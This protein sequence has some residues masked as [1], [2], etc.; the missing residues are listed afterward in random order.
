MIHLTSRHTRLRSRIAKPDRVRRN[1]SRHATLL[2]LVTAFAAVASF[3]AIA[4][5]PASA[6]AK[7][8]VVPTAYPT[9][10][11]AVDAAQS[12]DTI[13]VRPGTYR[14]QV[15]IGKNLT[16]IGSGP[17]L[18]TIRAPQTLAGGEDG[19]TS[20]VEIH[21]GASV[22]LSR[23]AVSGPGSGTCASGALGSGIRVLGGG[24]LDLSFARV[25]HLTDTPAAP[26]GIGGIPIRIGN[27][28]VGAGSATI[29]YTQISDYQHAGVVVASAEANATLSHDVITGPEGLSANG[30]EF[31][32]G[33]TGTVSDSIISGNTCRE[34]DPSCGPDIFNDAQQIGIEALGA[35]VAITRD[36]LYGNQI[37][38]YAIGSANISQAALLNNDLFGAVVQ[39]GAFSLSSDLIAGGV[40]GV[41]VLATS[42]NTAAQLDHVRIARTS[43]TPVQTIECCG[44]TATATR[45]P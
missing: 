11:S 10:Q 29:R 15:S 7:L 17:G 1:P 12:G 21:D 42:A 37:G 24:H 14:E 25:T 5:P 39:D 35:P 4:S 20:I 31:V 16:V 33:A 27:A 3:L 9:I 38:I 26:C 36:V 43:G 41:V 23:L 30:V 8:R 18:T 45:N 6:A 32:L 44:F 40:S 2:A 22:A 13:A 19:S 28:P 34:P